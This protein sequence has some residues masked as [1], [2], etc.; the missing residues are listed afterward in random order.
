MRS[1]NPAMPVTRLTSATKRLMVVAI[2]AASSLFVVADRADALPSN[3]STGRTNQ[4]AVGWAYCASGNGWFQVIIT[5]DP[6]VPFVPDYQRYGPFRVP[7]QGV[8]SEQYCGNFE[9]V[10]PTVRL[11]LLAPVN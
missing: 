6:W 11:G 7:G 4:N 2:L 10:R 3:C 1:A 9:S 5:C 8:R